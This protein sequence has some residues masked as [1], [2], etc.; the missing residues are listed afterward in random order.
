LRAGTSLLALAACLAT[1]AVPRA[2]YAQGFLDEFTSEGLRFSGFG[3]DFGGAWSDRL[4]PSFSGSFRV[5]MGSVAP[6]VRPML[7]VSVLRSGY[8]AD[9]IAILEERLTA[10]I[11]DPSGEARI[12]IDSLTLTNVTLDLD[13]QYVLQAGRVAPYAGLG[14]GVHLRDVRGPAIA[15]TIVE[16]AL[17]AVVAA[18]NG[19]AIAGGCVIAAAC[20]RRLM[21]RGEGKIG[22]PE[23]LVGVPY[24]TI[25]L[26]LMR[27]RLSFALLQ[28]AVLTARTYAA[29]MARE[30]GLVDE[31]VEPALLVERAVEIAAQMGSIPAAVFALAKRQLIAPVMD[32]VALHEREF[33]AEVARTWESPEALAA[34][35]AY[36]ERTLK[37]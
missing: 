2:G 33:E 26:E 27:A 22:V 7:S 28:E 19:H 37:K 32:A 15:G 3:M 4:D 21:A 34:V 11:V 20:D 24:P 16:D 29:D 5:D 9:E 17:Q 36:V 25:A 30:R 14:I 35:K 18:V 31:L 1:L 6:R 23:L 8:A 10:V 13:L 12:E